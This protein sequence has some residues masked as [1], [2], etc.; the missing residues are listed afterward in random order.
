MADRDAG[1]AG[2]PAPAA[3]SWPAPRVELDPGELG[4]AVYP[5]LNSLVVPRPIAWVS[6]RSAEGCPNLAPHSYF[7]VASVAP[8]VVAFTSVGA[9]DSL[10]NIRET[11]DFVVAIVTR[12]LA[13]QANITGTN[14]PA[15]HSEFTA[16]GLT[17]EPSVRVGAPRV[18]ESPIALEC[19]AVGERSFGTCTMV[20]GEVV[21]IAISPAVFDGAGADVELLH[22]V[23]RLGGDDWAEVAGV[24]ALHRMRYGEPGVPT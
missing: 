24:F 8:P 15:G 4:P 1:H 12:A 21:R 3:S 13:E 10:R 22:P 16:A 7:T 23:S 18:A 6:S 9:K 11:G 17:P 14:Y 20:F 5:L 2:D 19:R